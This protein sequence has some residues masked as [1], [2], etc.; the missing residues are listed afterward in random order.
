[1]SE[2]RALVNVIGNGEATIVISRNEGE[3]DL[4]RVNAVLDGMVAETGSVEVGAGLRDVEEHALP[5]QTQ[6]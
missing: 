6:I 3:L 4:A 2:A 1:M 5:V